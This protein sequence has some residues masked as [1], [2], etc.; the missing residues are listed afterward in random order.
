MRWQPDRFLAVALAMALAITGAVLG[1]SAPPAAAAPS[2]TGAAARAEHQRVVKFWTPERVAKAVPRDFIRDPVSGRFALEPSSAKPTGKPASKVVGAPWTSNVLVKKTTGKVFFK[3][4]PT[5]NVCSASVVDD[6]SAETSMILT[7]AHCVFDNTTGTFATE[8]MF[9]PDYATAV[10]EG[11][12][13]ESFCDSITYGCWTAQA[14]AVTEAF[15]SQRDFNTTATQN[16]YAFARVGARSPDGAQLDEVVGA[17]AIQ[18]TK[19]TT[20]STVDLFGYPALGN[21]TGTELVYSQGRLSVDPKNDKQTY[22]VASDL[23]SGSSGGPWLV[24]FDRTAGQGTVISVS[25]YR[26]PHLPFMQGPVLDDSTER[27]LAAARHIT[28]DQIVP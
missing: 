11:T 7:A 20:G 23:T 24:G 9:I 21:Y 5:F 25:S 13:D 26:Y 1:S 3:M 18:Y 27:L 2:D 12:L 10:V 22:R 6:G 8:W 14:L 15:A 19:G 17:Q 16:D 28:A 4:G